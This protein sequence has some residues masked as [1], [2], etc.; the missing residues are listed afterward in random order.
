[1]PSIYWRAFKRR[2][3]VI[4]PDLRPRYRTSSLRSCCERERERASERA[5]EMMERES[6]RESE[7]ERERERAR[8][9]AQKSEKD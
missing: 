8:A 9:R 2:S 5:R 7:R 4:S 1:L 6:A 3:G